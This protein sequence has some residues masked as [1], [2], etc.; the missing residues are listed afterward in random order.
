MIM[1]GQTLGAKC[2]FGKKKRKKCRTDAAPQ[3][4]SVIART[5]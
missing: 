1:S 4:K 2:A 5:G 3:Q